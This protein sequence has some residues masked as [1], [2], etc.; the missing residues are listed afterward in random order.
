M[1][2]REFTQSDIPLGQQTLLDP[3][4]AEPMESVERVVKPHS[5]DSEFE[6]PVK[7]VAQNRGQAVFSVGET[8]D[9]FV[10][11]AFVLSVNVYE[12]KDGPDRT[13]QG[14][15][16]S[17]QR[18]FVDALSELVVLGFVDLD[19]NALVQVVVEGRNVLPAEDHLGV[20]G[21]VRL[22]DEVRT[23]QHG[24]EVQDAEGP[25]HSESVVVQK[26][27][28]G[29][30]LCEK[31]PLQDRG[32]NRKGLFHSMLSQTS[33]TLEYEIEGTVLRGGGDLPHVQHA[34]DG[35]NGTDILGKRSFGLDPAGRN[36]PLRKETDIVIFDW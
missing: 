30:D 1:I 34:T 24:E 15:V 31:E 14:I 3:A 25:V 21:T 20:Y 26:G 33:D 9:R 7:L 23:P 5:L 29:R 17:S 8:K 6:P 10:A 35:A 16:S 19:Q 28:V 2:A 11:E 18:D 36:Q 32:R 27:C 4:V 22:G 13:D 12:G